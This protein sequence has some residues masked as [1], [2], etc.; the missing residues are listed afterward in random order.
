MKVRDEKAIHQVKFDPKLLGYEAI[1]PL[2][3]ATIAHALSR[4]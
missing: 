3:L 4:L 1:A 2:W